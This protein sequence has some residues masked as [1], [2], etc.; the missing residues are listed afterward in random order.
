MMDDRLNMQSSDYAKITFGEAVQHEMRTLGTETSA[1]SA[2]FAKM[3]MN[4]KAFYL[5]FHCM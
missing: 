3:V 1:Q 4:V 5:I 2:K